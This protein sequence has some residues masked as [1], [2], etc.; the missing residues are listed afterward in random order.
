MP[1]GRPTCTNLR[2][3][4]VIQSLERA[5]FLPKVA[6]APGI[7]GRPPPRWDVHPVL[8]GGSL[9]QTAETPPPRPK[10]THARL[11]MRLRELRKP[12][13]WERAT[14]VAPH[15]VGQRQRRARLE[16]HAPSDELTTGLP[17]TAARAGRVRSRRP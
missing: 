2:T 16:S 3:L 8:I 13:R 14:P 10:P 1:G 5:G 4:Q 7:N 6:A 17:T 12:H 15:A 11:A 9:A